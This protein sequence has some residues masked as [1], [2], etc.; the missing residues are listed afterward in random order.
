MGCFL[1][2]KSF[3]YWLRYGSFGKCF[4]LAFGKFPYF[5]RMASES[6]ASVLGDVLHNQPTFLHFGLELMMF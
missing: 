4:P 1:A 6:S 5:V 3:I 2:G